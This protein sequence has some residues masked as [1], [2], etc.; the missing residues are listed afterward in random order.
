LFSLGGCACEGPTNNILYY[1]SYLFSS[2]SLLF[3]QVW[4]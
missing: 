1:Y 3:P 4:R 2:N